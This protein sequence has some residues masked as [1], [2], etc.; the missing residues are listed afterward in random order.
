MTTNCTHQGCDRPYF[1][2]LNGKDVCERHLVEGMKEIG[3]VTQQ[4]FDE[5]QKL[6]ND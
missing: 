5:W 6:H 1:A 3:L 2:G 4:A